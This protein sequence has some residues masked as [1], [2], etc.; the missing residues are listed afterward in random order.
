MNKIVKKVFN[1]V[2]IDDEAKK[3]LLSNHSWI[4]CIIRQMENRLRKE[5]TD[6]RWT[7]VW[8]NIANYSNNN[9]T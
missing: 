6:K 9:Y 3:S 4:G 7:N 5:N 1:N 2:M 8:L